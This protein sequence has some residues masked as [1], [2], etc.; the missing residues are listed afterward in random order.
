MSADTAAGHHCFLRLIHWPL[1][2]APQAIGLH[3][4]LGFGGLFDGHHHSLRGEILK[5]LV[6]G[7]TWDAVEHLNSRTRETI[8]RS[9]DLRYKLKISHSFRCRREPSA[10]SPH[11]GAWGQ[12]E[13]RRCAQVPN[14]P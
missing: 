1:G 13:R 12:T 2:P 7:V 10:A 5:F 8:E 3:N 11:R 9:H 4:C 6:R 14:T